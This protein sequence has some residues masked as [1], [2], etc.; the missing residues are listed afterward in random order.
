MIMMIIC[1]VG[2]ELLVGGL[3]LLLLLRPALAELADEIYVFHLFWFRLDAR[4]LQMVPARAPA[5]ALIAALDPVRLLDHLPA[6]ALLLLVIFP[7]APTDALALLLDLHH[8]S[9]PFLLDHPLHALLLLALVLP[10]AL[11][12]LVNVLLLEV[13]EHHAL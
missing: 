7:R 9:R 5:L 13:V 11:L 1:S 4:A 6:N 2:L 12:R 10:L 8:H 3:A